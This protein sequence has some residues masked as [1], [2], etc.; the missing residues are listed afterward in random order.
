MASNLGHKLKQDWRELPDEYFEPRTFCELKIGQ[1]FIA[2]PEPGDNH[3][4][5]GFKESSYL[6]MKTEECN[7]KTFYTRAQGSAVN[8]TTGAIINFPYDLA[9]IIII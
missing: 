4:H 6:F 7:K 1:K 3:G 8:L 5:G 9:V 2:L